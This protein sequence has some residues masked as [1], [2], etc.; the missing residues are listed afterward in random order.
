MRI[1]LADAN[2]KVRAALRL[3][4]NNL[5][6]LVETCDSTDAVSLIAQ[7]T[8]SCPDVVLLDVDLPGAQLPRPPANP[9]LAELVQIIRTLCPVLKIIALGS[10]PA[11]KQPC[12]QAGADAFFCKS[13][14]PDELLESLALALRGNQNQRDPGVSVI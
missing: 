9:S 7:I 8:A 14:P 6:T 4:L 12:L 10:S 1:L 3:V 2:P 5:A 11:A 13:D